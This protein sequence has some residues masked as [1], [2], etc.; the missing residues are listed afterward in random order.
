MTGAV[1]VPAH[2]EERVLPR[3]LATLLEGLPEDTFGLEEVELVVG[4]ESVVVTPRTLGALVQLKAR[5]RPRG[6]Q[7]G[8]GRVLA[9][10][11]GGNP[12]TPAGRTRRGGGRVPSS[13]AVRSP[14][15][16]MLTTPARAAAAALSLVLL[17]PL[18]HSQTDRGP[19]PE[20]LRARGRF[21][22]LIETEEAALVPRLW[23]LAAECRDWRLYRERDLLARLVIEVEPDHA[24]ARKALKYNR[25]GDR[26]V[27]SPSY[28][29]PRSHAREERHA[30]YAERLAATL[31]PYKARVFRALERDARLLA[32]GARERT[33][34]KLLILAPDDAA[35]RTVLGERRLAD[36]WVLE[37]TAVAAEGGRAIA[38][39]A[40][41]ALDDV[42]R[43]RSEA[44]TRTERRLG[45]PWRSALRTPGV[46]VLGTT[47]RREVDETARVTEAVAGLFQRVFSHGQPHR[48]GYTIYLVQGAEEREVLLANM[49]GL[50]ETT[51][52]LLR[53][54]GGGWLGSGSRLG[55]W[56]P[57]PARR[58]DGAVRQTLGTL[59]MDAYGIDGRHGWA[60]EGMGL[61]L[62]YH[63]TGTRLTYFFG[64]SG[65]SSNRKT[66]LWPTLQAPETRWLAAAY[67]LLARDDA[68]GLE[69]LLGRDV[70]TMRDEDILVAYAVAAY[71]LEGRPDEAPIILRRIGAGE[72]PVLVFE[73]VTGESLPGLELRLRRWLGEVL[74]R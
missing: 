59:L 37:E 51:K 1:I 11:P 18:V 13:P 14:V 23:E 66:T 4:T 48:E 46:R 36:R 40:A 53:Q 52:G 72:H 41:A 49:P 15:P 7:R 45:V 29:V 38:A 25:Q 33:L 55:E 2:D 19:D 58:L 16:T 9:L 54:A 70:D 8:A 3:T 21:R 61:Y 22:R 6:V 73:D 32:L 43:P 57:N 28:R 10:I 56:D 47:P 5:S 39:L 67:D 34:R 31:D 62:V 30:L 35:L 63:M 20:A 64:R 68:P 12:S 69:F 74:V 44:Q 71:L 26:W 27:Q 50:P 60:W 17:A 42:D 24:G 65:Y